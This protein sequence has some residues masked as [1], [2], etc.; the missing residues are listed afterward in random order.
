VPNGSPGET[1]LCGGGV[2]KGSNEALSWLGNLYFL[3]LIHSVYICLCLFCL[4]RNYRHEVLISLE[5]LAISKK[6]KL[7]V[8]NFYQ[9]FGH[10]GRNFH[11]FKIKLLKDLFYYRLC[12]I[13]MDFK[14]ETKPKSNFRNKNKNI[15]NLNL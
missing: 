9:V 14:I 15:N 7:Q 13:K 11:P 2:R 10:R 4:H 1:G 12:C 5:Q 8:F 6:K 3:F